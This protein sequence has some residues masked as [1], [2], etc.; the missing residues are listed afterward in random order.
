MV[1]V[2]Q[3]SV[4][5]SLPMQVPAASPAKPGTTV[6][7]SFRIPVLYYHSIGVQPDNNAVLDPKKLEEQMAYL[8][9]EGYTTLTLQ[10]FLDIWFGR[11]EAPPKSVLLTFDDGYADNYTYAMPI[12]QKYKFHATMFMLP[13]KVGDGWYV[14][15]E[16]AREMLKAGW[17][18]QSHGMTHPYLNQLKPEQQQEEIDEAARLI[19][20]HLGVESEV[21]CYPYGVFNKETLRLLMERGY[22]AAF[23]IEQGFTEKTQNPLQMKRLFV[24]G[25][26]SLATFI[27]KLTKGG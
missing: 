27:Q 6:E 21:F 5:P 18:I 9:K 13:G 26:D 19:K 25:K 24:G 2:P 7:K 4:S 12:L 14:D 8:A 16:M 10:Q 20:E 23:T 1:I 3:A 17:D 15:W 11:M 22:K